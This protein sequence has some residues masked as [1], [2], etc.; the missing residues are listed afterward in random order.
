MSSK[1][2]SAQIAKIISKKFYLNG[3]LVIWLVISLRKVINKWFINLRDILECVYCEVNSEI[4]RKT[5]KWKFIE[6]ADFFL[7]SFWNSFL[8]IFYIVHY[9]LHQIPLKPFNSKSLFVRLLLSKLQVDRIS[10]FREIEKFN[11][12]PFN[13]FLH[14]EEI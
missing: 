2:A 13:Y 11:K 9:N 6:L 14:L 8:P 1:S 3:E 10:Q 4:S 5:Q 12:F 7:L